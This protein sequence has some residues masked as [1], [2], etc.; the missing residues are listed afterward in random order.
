[1]VNVRTLTLAQINT[2]TLGQVN[3]LL[4]E[5]YGSTFG[6]ATVAPA[7]DGVVSTAPAY[8]G[9]VSTQPAYEGVASTAAR[10]EG[11]ASASPAYLN[12]SYLGDTN[13]KTIH[14]F[15]PGIIAD[16]VTDVTDQLNSVFAAAATANV[17]VLVPAGDY[18]ISGQLMSI[19][20]VSLKPK[21]FGEG[22]GLTRFK[23]LN[24]IADPIFDIQGADANNRQSLFVMNGI[25]FLTSSG[26][27]VDYQPFRFKYAG[28]T[29]LFDIRIR[30]VTNTALDGE[31]WWDSTL[32]V[33]EFISGGTI[34][35]PM[36]N[37]KDSLSIPPID[38]DNCN[39]IDFQRCRWETIK[40]GIRFG[41]Y[42]RDN[43]VF[44]CKF[45]GNNVGIYAPGVSK[46]NDVSRCT[47]RAHGSHGIQLADDAF[48]WRIKDNTID[49]NGG[50]GVVLAGCT[51]TH[52]KDNS[53]AP[54]G[55][56]NGGNWT[57]GADITNEIEGN[58]ETPH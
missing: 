4:L 53:F 16:G 39:N 21:I 8:A 18:A 5:E 7:Y 40:M 35:T 36:V 2:L 45:E 24:A 12:E 1:M 44:R 30:N 27:N 15:T 25:G 10:Y 28:Y 17:S 6:L 47:F 50:A 58:T 49:A 3:D 33:V 46:M 57:G 52:L 41:E 23:I 29:H 51:Y 19:R 14:D 34:G 37:L 11:L 43:T 42:A 38:Y 13:M 9:L 48:N 56:N 22:R 54:L 31:S 20:S 26:A 55:N 32:T